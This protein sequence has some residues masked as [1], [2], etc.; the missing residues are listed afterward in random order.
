MGCMALNKYKDAIRVERPF[1][2]H[3]CL[4]TKIEGN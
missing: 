1:A 2:K 3:D 4:P